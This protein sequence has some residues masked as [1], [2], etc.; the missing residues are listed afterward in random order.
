MRERI[1]AAMRVGA[2]AVALACAVGSVR[3]EEPETVGVAR[4]GDLLTYSGTLTNATGEVVAYRDGLI[5]YAPLQFS[6]HAGASLYGLIWDLSWGRIVA[7]GDLSFGAGGIRFTAATR[8]CSVWE[9]KRDGS[10]L[11]VNEDQRWQSQTASGQIVLFD[12]IQSTVVDGVVTVP[13]GIRPD[14]YV[15]LKLGEGVTLTVSNLQFYALSAQSDCSRGVLRFVDCP[16]I[17]P[18]T[19]Q[20]EECAFHGRRMEF[21]GETTKLRLIGTISDL[22]TA[23][24]PVKYAV[25]T[26]ID[27]EHLARE[28]VFE[29]GAD[30]EVNT[31]TPLTLGVE[32]ISV[33]GGAGSVTTIGLRENGTEPGATFHQTRA[34][35]LDVGE[36]A[37]FALYGAMT[38]TPVWSLAGAG[39][40]TFKT[41]FVRI[42][43]VEGFT[44]TVVAA[45]GI[46][47][48]PPKS[49]W[50]EG[51][52]IETTGTG[53]FAAEGL[54]GDG[55]VEAAR[56]VSDAVE[57]EDILV[58]SGKVLY[59]A[60]DGLAAAVDRTITLQTGATL[61]IGRTAT[62]GATVNVTNTIVAVEADGTIRDYSCYYVRPVMPDV[63]A[64]FTGAVNGT[65]DRMDLP[66][67]VNHRDT[68]GK[69]ADYNV[70]VF[71][72]PGTNVL[73]GG[74]A[75]LLISVSHRRGSVILNAGLYESGRASADNLGG[76]ISIEG[77]AEKFSVTSS[78]AGRAKLSLPTMQTVQNIYIGAT[79]AV[80][81]FEV[82]GGELFLGNNRGLRIGSGGSS[83]T[84]VFRIGAGAQVT[85]TGSGQ[86]IVI[87]AK[88]GAKD[89][90]IF[91]RVEMTGGRLTSYKW[92]TQG[93]DTEATDR[94]R[95]FVWTGGVLQWHKD[96]SPVA[97]FRTQYVPVTIAGPDCVVDCIGKS[98][99]NVISCFA[100]EADVPPAAWTFTEHG[101]L[102]A[103]N[104]TLVINA[105]L[106]GA[107]LAAA[108]GARVE[109]L[110]RSCSY[111]YNS[112]YTSATFPNGA[113]QPR[114][115]TAMTH[116]VAKVTVADAA[117]GAFV[118]SAEAS[119]ADV[120][121]ELVRGGLWPVAKTFEHI[122]WKDLVFAD[123]SVL[124]G[125]RTTETTDLGSGSLTFSGQ[126][127]TA[128][129]SRPRLASEA[130]PLFKAAAV[131]VG[132]ATFVPQPG[133]KEAVFCSSATALWLESRGGLIIVR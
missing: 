75:W 74:G 14:S 87:G 108:A 20:G 125:S 46:V 57:T 96:V 31:K 99:T 56:F 66:N 97:F 32:K 5:V 129:A 89:S 7:E 10:G 93:G 120:T 128:F 71:D 83:A 13:G 100:T 131:D 98:V 85:C 132:A 43:S 64:T 45:S 79:A 102:T 101:R 72:G 95:E 38:G 113:E 124:S 112:S 21:C 25:G 90:Q 126:V 123:G 44:G 59:V 60:G 130:C 33:R 40:A 61:A 55:T 41:D 4:S 84:N 118:A 50:P 133:T 70:L 36:N 110:P 127:T 37:G 22:W 111:P 119:I 107:N 30:I 78:P 35:E 117:G 109:V 88:T 15:P 24:N 116:D 65:I 49:T 9:R 1:K 39:T 91:S 28:L 2:V 94:M 106:V 11:I 23:I 82:A 62:I 122:T 105:P 47:E 68:L 63:T 80:S 34:I 121:L 76:V 73:S 8:R 29:D 115:E 42:A 67:D 54:S 26:H 114:V 17:V 103:S 77:S 52:R 27:A 3:A 19:F 92:F 16:R 6:V 48:L 86:P 81:V 69:I 12:G 51:M 18:L 104:G 58:P 53:V